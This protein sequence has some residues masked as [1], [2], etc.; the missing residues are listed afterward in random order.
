MPITRSQIT[1]ELLWWAIAAAIAAALLLPPYL[2]VGPIRHGRDL[3]LVIV[4]FVTLARLLFFDRQTFWIGPMPVKGAMCIA[5]VPL[6]LFAV[7]TLNTVQTLVDAEG[8]HALFPGNAERNLGS[9]PLYVRSVAIF[10]SAGLAISA[11]L[12]PIRL[13]IRIWQ[14]MKH[15]LSQRQGR[16]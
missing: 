11:I 14:Q 8:L 3:A 16:L 1:A 7:L 12:L 9:W 4:A 10:S 6:F 2:A 15:K 5:C 13:I